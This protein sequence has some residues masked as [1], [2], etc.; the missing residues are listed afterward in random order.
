[1]K[2]AGQS[3]P[4]ITNPQIY[5]QDG[6]IQIFGTAQKG[7]FQA[8]IS[9]VLSAHINEDGSLNIALSSADLGPLP[10]P[11][12]FTDTITSL[13]EEAFT[14]SIGPIATGL[15]VTSISISEGQ[16]ILTGKMR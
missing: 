6:Q 12:G 11:D 1:M 2:L 10:V 3:E 14:G 13:I 16:I 15:R 7:Y 8:T 9:V 5:L 4:M